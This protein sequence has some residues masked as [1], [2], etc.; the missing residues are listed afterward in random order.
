VINRGGGTAAEVLEL[1]RMI[2]E[3]LREMFGVEIHPE[4]NFIGL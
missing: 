2:K 1:V 3:S 4:P